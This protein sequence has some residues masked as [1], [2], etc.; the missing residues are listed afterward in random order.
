M[1]TFIILI[2]FFSQSQVV[3]DTC[4]GVVAEIQAMVS[5]VYRF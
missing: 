2:A 5:R 4:N 1:L 3:A